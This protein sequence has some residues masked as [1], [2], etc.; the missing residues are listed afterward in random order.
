[1]QLLVLVLL[2]ALAAAIRI[3]F[4]RRYRS[5]SHI[6]G[7]PSP[8]WLF[9]HDIATVRQQEVGELDFKWVKE[10]GATWRIA[11]HLGTQVLMTADPKAM[12][13]IFHKSGY[14]YAKRRDHTEVTKMFT[15]PGI[16]SAQG[17]VHQRHRKIMNPAFSAP[18]LRSFLT[19]FQDIGTKMCDKWKTEVLD[20]SSG[21]VAVNKWL[22]RTTLD[23]IGEAA[24]AYDYGALDE[25]NDRLSSVY[26]NIF[27]KTS[28][29]PSKWL[30]FWRSMWNYFPDSLLRYVQ[31]TP[32]AE[33]RH[34]RHM[35]R[36]FHEVSSEVL[37]ELTGG[38]SDEDGKKD[39]MSI[40]VKANSSEDPKTQL[41]Y[42]EMTAQM[43]S[44]T[45]AGH[46]TTASTLSWM[47][48]E[49]A[50]HPEYQAKMREEIRATRAAVLARGE[51][52]FTID[53]LD[54][55]TS[56]MNAI[57]ETLRFHPIVF[58]LWREAV[59]DDVIPL[60]EPIVSATGE[61]ID[62]IPV[63]AGQWI[64]CSF[65]AYNRLPQVWGADADTWNPDRFLHIDL[66]K[67]VR[68]G[69][70]A[71][72][73]TFSAGIRGCIGWRFSVIEMQ[74]LAAELLERFEFGLPEEHYEIMRV[75]AGLM[76]PLVKDK[77]ELG[78]VM[79]LRVSLVH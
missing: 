40:L 68:V 65:C 8:S 16:I 2:F 46:E 50:K 54:S 12:Q 43:Q 29:H 76:I 17:E 67:Q 57:K 74:A 37:D 39:V 64:S 75:P 59:H 78:A 5:L 55:M 66:T 60:S 6:R 21:T 47:L 73:M 58:G 18:Q 13:H 10:Y 72:L 32:T 20:S 26:N 27:L 31:Y 7:P 71:N 33:H 34:M 52:R 70:F 25:R 45:F 3:V 23:I 77:L 22:A 30:V 11:S 19:L 36:V 56:V 48:W 38:I 49:L 24:F 4:R 51:T 41:D 61:V 35:T 79:P 53:D 63:R 15:G 1:M 69:V 44:L 14:N 42:V 9:G 28:L 62:S